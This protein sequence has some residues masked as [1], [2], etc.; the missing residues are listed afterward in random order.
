LT[1]S[2]DNTG[3]AAFV[4]DGF[5]YVDATKTLTFTP[6]ADCASASDI[7][8]WWD[9]Y[10]FN[11]KKNADKIAKGFVAGVTSWSGL[12]YYVEAEGESEI[13]TPALNGGTDNDGDKEGTRSLKSEGATGITKGSIGSGSVLAAEG[14]VISNVYGVV[15][16]GNK[17][18][19]TGA[20]YNSALNFGE[21]KGAFDKTKPDAT[22]TVAAEDLTFDPT[23]GVAMVAGKPEYDG[24]F[25]KAGTYT[26]YFYYNKDDKNK[27]EAEVHA[28]LTVSNGYTTPVVSVNQRKIDSLDTDAIR[29]AI[30]IDVDMNNNTSAAQS[31]IGT[32]GVFVA[33]KDAII[34]ESKDD[35]SKWK[36]DY[37]GVADQGIIIAVPVNA[38]FT[39]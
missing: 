31:F 19:T 21:S 10:E 27:T 35:G 14:S 26:A 3:I 38:T 33:D 20:L 12:S 16:F 23:S 29:G 36:A 18:S 6:S 15:K 32:G 13:I 39:L 25:A 4:A 7:A 5:S 37:L 1:V 28:N 24:V 17:Y 2:A 9:S 8:K 34:V 11:D 22:I 30:S